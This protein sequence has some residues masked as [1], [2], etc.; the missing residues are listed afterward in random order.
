MT[1]YYKLKNPK[2]KITVTDQW[3]SKY[4]RIKE[5]YENGYAQ[6]CTCGK[7]LYWK[8]LQCGHF[9]SRRKIP[10][11]FHEKNT[12]P[13]C[14]NCNGKNKGEQGKHAIYI[15]KRYGPG[16]AEMLFNIAE[17][18]GV[19]KHT[20]KELKELSSEFRKKFRAIAKYKGI[21]V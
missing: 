15:D 2:I 13:Q 16:T 20:K 12:H 1:A 17:M 5:A 19:K 14:S 4:I 6:C 9:V 8:D 7:I 10:T 11:R 3:Y 21:E 18:R